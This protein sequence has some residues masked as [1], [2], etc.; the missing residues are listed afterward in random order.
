LILFVNW[1]EISNID[2]LTLLI[3]LLVGIIGLLQRTNIF[4]GQ[5]LNIKL[6]KELDIIALGGFLVITWGAWSASITLLLISSIDVLMRTQW[7]WITLEKYNLQNPKPFIAAAV[8]P[9]VMWILWWTMLGQVNGLE[10]WA[11]PHPRELDPGRIVVKGGYVGARDNPPT[12]WM[13]LLIALPL[14]LSSTA[15]VSKLRQRNLSLRPY[16]LALSLQLVGCFA[17]LAF[18][19]PFPRLVFS[20]TWNIVFSIFQILAVLLSLSLESINKK[21][22]QINIKIVI[23][24]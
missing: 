5:L 2:L 10:A 8:L 1:L 12:E 4:S 23:S 14:L 22:N 19:P 7:K 3:I 18:A 13:S 15:I 21:V 9:L 24:D 20:L 17:T 16:A 11:L 6:P